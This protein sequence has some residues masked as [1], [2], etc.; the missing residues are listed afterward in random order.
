MHCTESHKDNQR[1]EENVGEEVEMKK[2]KLYATDS[3]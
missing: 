1:E 3:T 2:K